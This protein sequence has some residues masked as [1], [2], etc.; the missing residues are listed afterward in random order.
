MI[1]MKI[2]KVLAIG[3]LLAAALLGSAIPA[4]AATARASGVLAVYAGPGSGYTLVGKLPKGAQV[5]VVRCTYSGRWCLVGN[6]SRAQGWV[7][8][9]YLVGAA[10]KLR[11]SP[12]KFLVNP[13]GERRRDFVGF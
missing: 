13:F 5:D 8:A 10:A 1:E 3:G 2:G 4:E 12:P 6:G 9:S 7:L 11:A